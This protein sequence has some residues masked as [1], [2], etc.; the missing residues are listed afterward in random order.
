MSSMSLYTS[1]LSWLWDFSPD[2][3]TLLGREFRWYGVLFASGLYA[4]YLV[5]RNIFS[6]EG[7]PVAQVDTILIYICLG[8]LI[9]ARLGHV[10]FY[11]PEYYLKHPLEILYLWKGGL[12]S[13]GATVGVL[14]VLFLCARRFKL[15]FLTFGDRIVIVIA[16]GAGF[17]RLGNFANS[18]VYGKPTTLPQGV[19]HSYPVRSYL[20]KSL[21]ADVSIAPAKEGLPLL[22]TTLT[23]DKTLG[24]DTARL[25]H[26]LIE[27]LPSVFEYNYVGDHAQLTP[28]FPAQLRI[29]YEKKATVAR[30]PLKG[31]SRHPTQLYEAFFVA[32]LALALY[33]MWRRGVLARWPSGYMMGYFFVALFVFRFLVEFLKESQTSPPPPIFNM[34]QWLSVP[35]IAFGLALF[36]WRTLRKWATPN[37]GKND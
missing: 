4:G 27:R 13:H 34:G 14:S 30:L 31:I 7:R 24:L 18:E 32:L 8:I 21:Q 23:Y 3:F 11:S 10:L 20:A 28:N 12:A 29:S 33:V 35:M 6:R 9:G 5:L 17:I 19:V 16:V 36:S 1:M 26:L 25:R 15:S 2:I 22:N 37:Q